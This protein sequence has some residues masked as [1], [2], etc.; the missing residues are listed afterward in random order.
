MSRANASPSPKTFTLA[1]PEREVLKTRKRAQDVL[2]DF[3]DTPY[4]TIN[5]SG[6]AFG[7]P[8]ANVVGPLLVKLA[9]QRCLETAILADI[10]ASLPE[11]EALRSLSS[12]AKSI[13]VWKGLKAVDLSNNALGS[14]GLAQCEALLNGQTALERVF[15]SEA[16]LAAESARLL[17]QYLAPGRE[18]NLRDIDV[19][20]NR[21]ES[22]G[23]NHLSTIVAKSPRLQRLRVSTLGANAAAIN[24]LAKALNSTES[25]TE[26][27][28]SDNAIDVTAATSLAEVL[29]KQP[30]LSRLCLADL[31]MS[32]ETLK[33]ILEPLIP[34]SIKLHELLLA[35]NEITAVGMEVLCRYL[36]AH[37]TELRVL[38]LSANEISDAGA[39]LLAE[40]ICDAGAQCALTRVQIAEN[41]CTALPIV[42][43]A[44]E[45]VKLPA[46][47]LFDL[48][49]NALTDTVAARL[50][51][52]FG[53][54]VVRLGESMEGAVSEET[55]EELESALQALA[56]MADVVERPVVPASPTRSRSTVSRLV[57]LFSGGSASEDASE[58]GA[59][60]EKVEGLSR[61]A[62][63]GGSFVEDDSGVSADTAM[64]TPPA[65]RKG[66]MTTSTTAVKKGQNEEK[67]TDS[68]YTPPSAITG[69]NSKPDVVLSARKLK[70][71]LASLNKE[72][73]DAVLGELKMPVYTPSPS[74]GIGASRRRRISAIGEDNCV[75]EYLLV[76]DSAVQNDSGLGVFVD[77]LGG[78][79]VGV[80]VVVL[81]LAIAQSQEETTFSYRLV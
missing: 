29:L 31:N 54:N 51:S 48:R 53:S 68:P 11:D 19:H 13:G 66:A 39:I 52:A 5:L 21:L 59:S 37:E 81:V 73:S 27:D 76:G 36:K 7:D 75:N 45:L 2:K 55:G 4:T 61:S 65:T 10:I 12:I 35:G 38:D 71:S 49:G 72:M 56:D 33:A 41:E 47:K 64:R 26:L 63:S 24:N 67:G 57:S 50:E 69:S 16:G 6:C 22:P 74:R 34:A 15:L 58:P 28:L 43:L 23:L 44:Q 60:L 80:F 78:L 17:V 62:V 46:L 79:L 18:T 9:K 14:R 42:R 20:S 70:D 77:L 40:A 1:P 32:D 8:G 3:K 30:N 25:L